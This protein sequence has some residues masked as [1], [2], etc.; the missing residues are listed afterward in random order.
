M[1]RPGGLVWTTDDCVEIHARDGN[2]HHELDGF[3]RGFQN[4]S[5]FVLLLPCEEHTKKGWKWWEN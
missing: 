2:L 4:N 5:T 1:S 3:Y